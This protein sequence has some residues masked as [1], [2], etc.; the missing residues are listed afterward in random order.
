MVTRI[1]EIL[2]SL[3]GVMMVAGLL[4]ARFPRALGWF[5]RLPG[6][7]VTPNVFAPVA[8]MLVVSLGLSLLANLLGWLLRALR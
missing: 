4:M 6:D 5:G 7:I 3:G 1:G 8:S 2:F